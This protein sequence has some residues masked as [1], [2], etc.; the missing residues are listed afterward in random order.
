MLKRFLDWFGDVPIADAFERRNAV[1][2]QGLLLLIVPWAWMNVA[3]GV[4]MG[5][6]DPVGYWFALGSAVIAIA[7][8]RRGLFRPA[9]TC[10]IAAMLCAPGY[11]YWL[12]GF[13]A[14]RD[15]QQEHYVLMVMSALTLGRR[16]LWQVYLAMLALLAVSGV[17]DASRLTPGA[18]MCFMQMAGNYLFVAIMLDRACLILR[19]ARSDALRQRRQREAVVVHRRRLRA[20]RSPARRSAATSPLVGGIAHDFGHILELVLGFAGRRGELRTIAAP[21]ERA[22]AMERMLARVEQVAHRGAGLIRKLLAHSR[23]DGRGV[24]CFD[25][26]HALA[27][28]RPMLRQLFPPDVRLEIAVVEGY[29][30]RLD[31]D[32]FELMVL[33]IAANARDALQGRSGRFAIGLACEAGF[34]RIVF[35]DDG[36]GMDEDTRRRMFDPLFSVKASGGGHGFGLSGVMDFLRHAGGGIEVTSGIGAGTS[37]VVRLPCVTTESV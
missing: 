10:F 7:L 29:R 16:A 5:G 3:T 17:A 28:F 2:V 25:A 26:G 19:D 4:R 33:N 20:Q 32:E 22:L 12:S 18:L 34:V 30:I 13:D 9:V 6:T 31:R 24:A 15:H 1:A 35:T 14:I 21:D 8:I 36:I 27:A 37:L 11:Y 23:S